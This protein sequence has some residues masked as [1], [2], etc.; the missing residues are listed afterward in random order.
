[1]FGSGVQCELV[2]ASK[3]NGRIVM[4]PDED[5]QSGARLY[6]D[7]TKIAEDGLLIRDGAHLKVKD[8]L[9]LEPY[10][11]WTATWMNV[12]IPDRVTTPRI[13]AEIADRIFMLGE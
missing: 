3:Q 9:Q 11:L 8:F 12:G 4:D 7:A 1:M 13:F 2:V 5:Y 10:W 6:F